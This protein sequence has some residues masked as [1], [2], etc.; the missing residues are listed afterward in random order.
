MSC[1]PS[2]KATSPDGKIVFDCI[3]TVLQ[4]GGFPI[5]PYIRHPDQLN[6]IQCPHASKDRATHWIIQF[7]PAKDNPKQKSCGSITLYA[8]RWPIAATEGNVMINASAIITRS[9]RTALCTY[10]SE[11][12]TPLGQNTTTSLPSA[13]TSAI[14]TVPENLTQAMDH[15]ISLLDPIQ[16]AALYAMKPSTQ[17]SGSAAKVNDYF[18][19]L[20]LKKAKP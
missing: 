8:S 4:K 7:P 12:H 11:F 6:V 14:S 13:P 19:E 20:L 18:N 10:C 15:I 2:K 17:P 1:K 16:A 9:V 3:K 5:F